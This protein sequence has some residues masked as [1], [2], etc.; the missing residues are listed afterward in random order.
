MGCWRRKEKISWT[1]RMGNELLQRV[2]E[3]KNILHPIKK[4]K[5]RRVTSCE[6]SAFWNTTL[7][8]RGNDTRYGETRKEI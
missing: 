3:E 5:R 6:E 1:D 2:E 7:K 4:K 8:D